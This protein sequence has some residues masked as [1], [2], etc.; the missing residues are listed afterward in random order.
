MFNSLRRAKVAVFFFFV[1]TAAV[2]KSFYEDDFEF[3]VTAIDYREIFLKCEG[4][5]VLQIK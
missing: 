3:S 2:Y 4:C 5:N 1:L